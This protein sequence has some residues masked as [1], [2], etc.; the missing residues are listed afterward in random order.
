MKQ[1]VEQGDATGG[2]TCANV[3]QSVDA[4]SNWGKDEMYKVKRLPDFERRV[5]YDDYEFF[6]Y[7]DI[8]LRE[9]EQEARWSGLVLAGKWDGQHFAY[10]IEQMSPE[11]QEILLEDLKWKYS[12]A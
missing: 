12:E 7:T 8:E 1:C 9:L 3:T 11:E 2:L 5:A 10:T 4:L 6:S